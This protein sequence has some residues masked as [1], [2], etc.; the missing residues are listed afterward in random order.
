MECIFCNDKEG[1]IKLLGTNI[2]RACMEDICKV[3][4]SNERYDYYKE[5]VKKILKNY[6]SQKLSL[7]PVE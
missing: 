6:I 5:M 3:K 7:D 1:N 4:V 2:C